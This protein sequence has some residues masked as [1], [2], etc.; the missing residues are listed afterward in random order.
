MVALQGVKCVAFVSICC[1]IPCIQT[2]SLLIGVES[3]NVSLSVMKSYSFSRWGNLPLHKLLQSTPNIH[4]RYLLA[5]VDSEISIIQWLST[6]G[7]CSSYCINQLRCQPLSDEHVRGI[8]CFDG[9][10]GDSTER[11]ACIC[12]CMVLGEA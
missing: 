10:R 11:E 7:C 9:V 1:S 5:I 12:Y 4:W 6:F 3:F 8:G 2:N